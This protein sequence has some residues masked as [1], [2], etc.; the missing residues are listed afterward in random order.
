MPK[1]NQRG[2][3]VYRA[4][5]LVSLA[6][7]AGGACSVK[8][9]THKI[10]GD[11][12]VTMV[13]GDVKRGAGIEV[14][15]AAATVVSEAELNEVVVNRAA[16]YGKARSLYRETADR[17][18]ADPLNKVLYLIAIDNYAKEVGA[19][20]RTHQV[21]GVRTD[22]NGRFE[23]KDLK[24]GKYFLFTR[25]QVFDEALVWMVPIDLTKAS[26]KVDLSN[27]NQGLPAA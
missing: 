16:G 1:V 23:I 5:L 13:S 20:A 19:V 15:L 14:M 18:T 7:F 17:S 2:G 11:V 21:Q 6:L 3:G 10:S 9:S 27:H 8:P 25:L 4:V 26:Q 24:P 12:F 22:S